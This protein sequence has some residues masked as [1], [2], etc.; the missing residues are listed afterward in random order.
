MF[1]REDTDGFQK[2]ISKGKPLHRRHNGFSEFNL[3]LNPVIE[4]VAG[5]FHPANFR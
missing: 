1:C 2:I 5:M 4:E 3:T